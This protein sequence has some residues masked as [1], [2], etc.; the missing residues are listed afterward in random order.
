MTRKLCY[1][2]FSGPWSCSRPAELHYAPNFIS[3]LRIQ[4]IVKSEVWVKIS[5]GLCSKS[6]QRE[7]HLVLTQKSGLF[8]PSSTLTDKVS[9]SLASSLCHL[10]RP[11]RQ[12]WARFHVTPAAQRLWERSYRSASSHGRC[13]GALQWNWVRVRI[14]E[15]VKWDF[16]H[17]ETWH[18]WG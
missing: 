16:C 8:N 2:S 17:F 4:L 6:Q 14:Q 18:L 5:M 3:V 9:C 13:H 1:V 12:S 11:S 10:N 7:K 15:Q